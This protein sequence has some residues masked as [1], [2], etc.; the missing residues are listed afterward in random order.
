MGKR[1]QVVLRFLIEK[2]THSRHSIMEVW[3][4]I[5]NWIPVPQGPEPTVGQWRNLC[6]F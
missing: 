4:P 3:A 6:D 5:L 2:E 1:V